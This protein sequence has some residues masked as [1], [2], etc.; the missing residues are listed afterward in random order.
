M[1]TKILYIFFV[2]LMVSCVKESEL[3]EIYPDSITDPKGIIPPE[4]DKVPPT[5][6]DPLPSGKLPGTTTSVFLRVSTDEP[7][8]CH[9][10]LTDKPVMEMS[11]NF[12]RSS[13]GLTHNV[14]INVLDGRTYRFY[15]RCLD[16]L[17]NATL[18]STQIVFSIDPK[19]VVDSTPPTISGLSPLGKLASGTKS[20]LLSLN[21]NE[22]SICKHSLNSSANYAQMSGM[23]TQNG[24]THTFNVSGLS[25]G[26]SYSYYVL[27]Q[28]LAGNLSTKANI[29]FSVNSIELDGNILYANNCMSCHGNVANST[30]VNR[31]TAQIQ[32]A[33][34]NDGT[35]KTQAYL[36]ALTT[37]QIQAIAGVLTKAD[38]EPPV[39]LSSVESDITTNSAKI[40]WTLNEKANGQIEYGK[41]T[42]YGMKSSLISSFTTNH[43]QSLSNLEQDTTYYYR[44]LSNDEAGNKL[45]STAKTFKT[46]GVVNQPPTITVDKSS[47]TVEAGKSVVFTFTANDPEGKI[48]DWSFVNKPRF[49]SF[50]NTGTQVL[51]TL[52]PVLADVKDYPGLRMR[53]TDVEGLT[54]EVTFDL[55]VTAPVSNN[56]RFAKFKAVMDKSCVSCHGAPNSQYGG[57]A[58]FYDK[59]EAYWTNS[60]F[61]NGGDAQGSL[62]YQRI[63][64]QY[65][66]FVAPGG[67]AQNMPTNSGNGFNQEDADAIK[68][69]INSL[70][71]TSLDCSTI[72]TKPS[73]T[74]VR[75]LNKIELKTAISDLLGGGVIANISELDQLPQ[76]GDFDGFATV[77]VRQQTSKTF[78]TTYENAIEKI[79]DANVTKIIN[80]SPSNACIESILFPIA[81]RAWSKELTTSDQ[82]EIRNVVN[83]IISNSKH[84]FTF[85]DGINAGMRYIL[86]SPQFIYAVHSSAGFE[87]KVDAFTDY[88]L[89]KRLSLLLWKSIPDASLLDV[90]KNE[91]LNNVTVLTRE[92]KRMIASSKFAVSRDAF[93]QEWL[94]LGRLNSVNPSSSI[95]GV[96]STKFNALRPKMRQEILEFV[97]YVSSN[98]MSLDNFI[99]GK[100]TIADKEL[101]DHYLFTHPGGGFQRV[102][103]LPTD[104]RGGLSTLGGIIAM[105]SNTDRRSIVLSGVWFLNALLCDDPQA[106]GNDIADDIASS[107]ASNSPHRELAADRASNPSCSGCH[108]VIDGAGLPFNT[109][110]SV[111]RKT[112]VDESG[113]AVESFGEIY[114]KQFNNTH[115]FLEI[116]KQKNSFKACL[117]N[118]ML[119]YATGEMLNPK[120]EVSDRCKAKK[121]S[122]GLTGPNDNLEE[123]I[124]G[125]V[126]SD[127]FLKRSVP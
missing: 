86:L 65:T 80:C 32:N 21:S 14:P 84:A 119:I 123:L 55:I 117:T 126:R 116:I 71:T 76:D 16:D 13:D 6:N 24:L 95:Y 33:I 36:K 20:I 23:N 29:Q 12:V 59:S 22:N 73:L 18:S 104:A 89:A 61:I 121:I 35:M 92:A 106:P 19:T 30:K 40:S 110:D 50:L 94:R 103:F 118:K 5:V 10:D 69:Y 100:F 41:T 77:G 97:K 58:S 39:L 53:V 31:T 63:K 78:V 28:D 8:N 125:V 87:N 44:I 66:N 67:L 96:S 38:R 93:V 107:L 85:A 17:E 75:R 122:D 99:N 51:I 15:V 127:N 52:S 62:V 3:E 124:L 42:G 7:S 98:K 88:E 37:A 1:G 74:E 72:D 113:R 64:K 48:L 4:V 27:C 82:T 26:S 81:R 91:A 90:A 120:E 111:G 70:S 60:R 112:S 34:S 45:V 83:S 56:Q 115:E 102:N 11:S 57:L 43:T 2:L 79:L 109:F 47:A 114:L 105:N 9:Y 68:D 108:G 49:A 46:I 101:A 25:D 54:A